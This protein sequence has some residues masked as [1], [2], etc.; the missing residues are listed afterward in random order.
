MH[1]T[2]AATSTMHECTTT[3]RVA[4]PQAKINWN[5]WDTFLTIQNL[6][7]FYYNLWFVDILELKQMACN[8]LWFVDIIVLNVTR[9]LSNSS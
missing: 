7:F 2:M 4:F 1:A 8:N 6:P 5:N 3:A 9:S